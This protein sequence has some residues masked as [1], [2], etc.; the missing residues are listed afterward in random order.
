MI[1]KDT[2]I[3]DTI[4]VKFL[5]ATIF[6][7]K[8]LG[9][10]TSISLSDVASTAKIDG[11]AIARRCLARLVDENLG[12]VTPY[13]EDPN[14]KEGFKIY[15]D[16]ILFTLDEMERGMGSQKGIVRTS[17]KTLDMSDGYTEIKETIV[18]SE[19]LITSDMLDSYALIIGVE[20]Y[21]EGS[22]HEVAFAE[23]DATS[24]AES[25]ALHGF[26]E[27]NV[28][29]LLGSKATKTTIESILRRILERMTENSRFILFYAGHGFSENDH[30]YITCYDTQRGDLSRTSISLQ[31][32]LNDIKKSKSQRAVF[33]LDSCHSGLLIDDTMRGIFSEMAENELDQFFREAEYQVGFASC[34]SDQ[35]SY[36]SPTLSHGIWTYHLIEALK[37]NALSALEN[38][39]YLTANSLQNYLKVAV[40]KS[41]RTTTV[42]LKNQT[43]CMFGNL[44]NEFRIADLKPILD[45]R[46][47]KATPELTKLKRVLFHNVSHGK[48]K[49]LSGFLAHH[50][51]VPSL[52]ND[53]TQK[54][55]AKISSKEVSDQAN[56][57]YQDIKKAFN[58][59]RT[60][61]E[62]QTSSDGASIICPDFDLDIRL[63][64]HPE[65]PTEY[66]LQIDLLHIRTPDK[67]QTP[68]F[69]SLF[70]DKFNA[71]IFEFDKPI[72]LEPIID[73]IEKSMDRTI[74][75][76]YPGNYSYCVIRIRDFEAEIVVDQRCFKLEFQTCHT[77]LE[78]IKGLNFVQSKLL[79]SY[80]ISLPTVEEDSE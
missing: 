17:P 30:N 51:R 2:D 28:F 56:R 47:S 8:Q 59:K 64:Q 12:R 68:E 45:A 6:E 23:A 39:R 50:H 80:R 11:L 22:I 43:P 13:V 53:A 32:I 25:L 35:H 73:K 63:F 26:D 79:Q 69:N 58:Y 55:V 52:V 33:F 46:A 74:S 75:L 72:S 9:L 40:P 16:K 4:F 18:V 77:P 57:F 44:T 61:I 27:K 38:N 31:K 1:K 21:Q 71:I 66:L 5:R 67:V 15:K 36:S 10:G 20:K 7:D 19:N 78:L 37:G 76:E 70:K 34:K 60:D 48:I 65:S 41:L 24:I 49:S 42:D 3:D 29:L 62:L 54:F 14:V